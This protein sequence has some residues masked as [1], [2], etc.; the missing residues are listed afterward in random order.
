MPGLV[1]RWASSKSR[2][3]SEWAI[4]PK[5][6]QAKDI[7]DVAYHVYVLCTDEDREGLTSGIIQMVSLSYFSYKSHAALSKVHILFSACHCVDIG[8]DEECLFSTQVCT[9]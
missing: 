6:T 7:P 8:R 1:R 9:T 3:C 4:L 2:T 5:G